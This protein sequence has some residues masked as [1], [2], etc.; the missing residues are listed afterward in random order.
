MK[1]HNEVVLISSGQLTVSANGLRLS[2]VTGIIEKHWM[3]R[4]GRET[5][6]QMERQPKGISC[7]GSLGLLVTLALMLW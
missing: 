6:G 1:Q 4:R 3:S 5:Q 2:I 7:S